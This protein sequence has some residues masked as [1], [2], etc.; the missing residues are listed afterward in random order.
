VFNDGCML[1]MLMRRRG[2]I[3]DF[4]N[5]DSTDYAVGFGTM[6]NNFWLG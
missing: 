2:N 6:T 5:K 4:V 3:T 1:Q